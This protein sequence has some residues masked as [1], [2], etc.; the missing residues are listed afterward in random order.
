MSKAPVERLNAGYILS[1]RANGFDPENEHR[2]Y[3]AVFSM[4]KLVDD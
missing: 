2:L 3:R 4:R 1:L